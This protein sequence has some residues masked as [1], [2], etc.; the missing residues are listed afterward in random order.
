[1]SDHYKLPTKRPL[2]LSILVSLLIALVAPIAFGAAFLLVRNNGSFVAKADYSND[3]L[4]PE[5]GDMLMKYQESLEYTKVV[6]DD[7]PARKPAVL[8]SSTVTTGQPPQP[9][10]SKILDVPLYQ[11]IYTLSCEVT[12]VEMILSYFGTKGGEN[13]DTLMQKLG[14]ADP[15]V[16]EF[17]GDTMI[18]GDPDKGFVGRVDGYMIDLNVGIR[19]A[20]GWGVDKGPTARLLRQF[21]PQ[22]YEGTGSINSLISNLDQG[23]PVIY[24]HVRDEF[25]PEVYQYQTFSGKT[26]DLKQYHV[27]L[28]T[29]YEVDAAGQ[30]TFIIND[31]DFGQYRINSVDLDRQW[32]KY[33]Y[34]MVVA[35]R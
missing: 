35:V 27:A 29:G 12:T 16:P 33:N 13:Q 3:V 28:V 20:T 30:I 32:G 9:G 4:I 5:E 22:S 8:G 18:W 10:Q 11:Q 7:E 26:V 24:W 23:N 1:M 21:H 19:G 17:R 15:I 2:D 31:P 34:D 14:Y 6:L 25:S